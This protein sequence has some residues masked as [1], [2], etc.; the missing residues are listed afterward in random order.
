MLYDFLISIGLNIY[1]KG[2]WTSGWMS[3]W[4]LNIEN[5][6]QINVLD[7]DASGK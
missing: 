5:L 1:C 3:G 7:S 2:T 4:S 6:S